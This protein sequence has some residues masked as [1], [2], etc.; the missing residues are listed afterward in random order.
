MTQNFTITNNANSSIF[1]SNGDTFHFGK[2]SGPGGSGFLVQGTITTTLINPPS[3]FTITLYSLPP[4]QGLGDT[5]ATITFKKGSQPIIQGTIKS[6]ISASSSENIINISIAS[7][8]LEIINKTTATFTINNN[9]TANPNSTNYIPITSSLNFPFDF[10]SFPNYQFTLE[11][12][13]SLTITKPFYCPDNDQI[14]CDPSENNLRLCTPICYCLYNATPKCTTQCSSSCPNFDTCIKSCD[15]K[16]DDTLQS[17]CK[18]LCKGVFP[19]SENEINCEG[20]CIGTKV[21][22]CIENFIPKQT[23]VSKSTT[24]EFTTYTL[25]IAD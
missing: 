14:N 3:S 18:S 6:F 13:E 16:P 2:G 9:I 4:S 8:L 22:S 11:L 19:C 21:S 15:S 12:D 1:V 10:I 7:S 5:L 24:D 25:T 23:N 17:T 20:K